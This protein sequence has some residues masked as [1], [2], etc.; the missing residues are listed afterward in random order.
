MDRLVKMEIYEKLAE[1]MNFP[2]AIL[3][4]TVRMM[5]LLLSERDV[6]IL[7]SLPATVS[8][9]ADQWGLNSEQMETK[10]RELFIKG[11]VTPAKYLKKF[12]DK[13]PPGSYMLTGNWEP[14]RSYNA[15]WADCPRAVHDFWREFDDTV[16][17]E[18]YNTFI[19][20]TG[21]PG[22]RIL[23]VQRDR[24]SR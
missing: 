18:I 11:Y 9:L 7:L 1:Q 23:P 17:P 19:P 2:K 8:D 5:R 20:P 6:E 12:A 15:K 3:N 24:Q 10:I 4:K 22:S 16:W 13:L 21:K 14:L